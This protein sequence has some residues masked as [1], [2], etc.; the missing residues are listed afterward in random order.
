MPMA[1]IA[2]LAEQAPNRAAY[3]VVINGKVL[4]SPSARDE[5]RFAA[6]CTDA[7]LRPQQLLVLFWGNPVG[8]Q[9]YVGPVFGRVVS[10]PFPHVG[11]LAI[12]AVKAAAVEFRKGQN[13]PA[14]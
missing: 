2:A 6:N 1:G 8:L 13:Q 12:L 10:S 7:A 9:K 5:F 3:M 11:P 4:D 14:F